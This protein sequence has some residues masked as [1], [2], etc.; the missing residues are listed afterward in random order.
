MGDNGLPASKPLVS[1][2]A[3]EEAEHSIPDGHI[4]CSFAFDVYIESKLSTDIPRKQLDSHIG[5][6]S[7]S[8]TKLIYITTHESRPSQLPSKVL[9]TNWIQVAN[10]LADFLSSLE[11]QNPVFIYLI[12][13]FELMLDNLGFCDD[14]KNR[15]VIVGGRM[16]EPVA[17][18]YGFYACQANRYFRPAKYL[19]F[20]HQNRIKYLFRIVKKVENANLL[21][22]ELDVPEEY[23]AEREPHYEV[24]PEPRTFFRLEQVSEFNREI[25]NNCKDKNGKGC[26][27]TQKQAYTDYDTFMRAKTTSELKNR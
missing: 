18:E 10:C 16:G 25:K 14:G 8:S 21:D 22:P 6:L 7:N 13:Q 3:T 24:K 27:F 1:T 17:I 9:W 11:N 20:A 23:F 2:Q 26:A 5:L 12:E 4:S 15:V 19:A